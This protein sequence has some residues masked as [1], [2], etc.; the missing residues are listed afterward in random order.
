MQQSVNGASKG[1]SEME[2]IMKKIKLAHVPMTIQC[3][4]GRNPCHFGLF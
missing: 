2:V 4:T 3:K 1:R